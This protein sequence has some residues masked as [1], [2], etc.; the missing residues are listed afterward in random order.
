MR[1]EYRKKRGLVQEN[2][3]LRKQVA[4]LKQAA[5]ERRRVEDGLR[6]DREL[7]R[8]LLNQSP[9]PLCL[10]DGEGLPLLANQSFVELLGYASPG[11]LIRLAGALGLV[12]G[13]APGG[14]NDADPLL[15]KLVLRRSDG[16]GVAHPVL[17][18]MVPGTTYRSLTVMVSAQPA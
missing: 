15:A 4:D 2:T 13:H 7:L 3:D 1:D 17:T 10:V 11:E 8:A 6:H 9:H 5:L 14:S 16:V 12:L 18:A